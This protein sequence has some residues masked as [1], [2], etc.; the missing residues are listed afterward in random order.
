MLDVVSRLAGLQRDDC[1]LHAT[2][3][4]DGCRCEPGCTDACCTG[5]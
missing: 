1:A 2:G 3:D 4:I 5:T